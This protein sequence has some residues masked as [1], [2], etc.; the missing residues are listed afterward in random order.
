MA[1]GGAAGADAYAA[2]ECRYDLVILDISMPEVNG[3]ECFRRIRALDAEAAVLICTGYGAETQTA[4]MLE[5]GAKGILRK[6]FETSEL[7]GAVES[8]KRR[9]P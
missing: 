1:H 2:A 3:A 9:A 5:A 6:P 4:Q 8:L 7:T